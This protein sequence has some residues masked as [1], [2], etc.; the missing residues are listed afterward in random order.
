ME[1]LYRVNGAAVPEQDMVKGPGSTLEGEARAPLR[2]NG[3]GC[4]KGLVPLQSLKKAASV[5]ACKHA[6]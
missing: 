5:Q 6:S 1:R 3:G 4:T 2:S